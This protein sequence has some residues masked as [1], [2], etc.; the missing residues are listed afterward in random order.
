MIAA[1]S[2]YVGKYKVETEAETINVMKY[3]II[4]IREK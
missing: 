2:F 4:K 3:Q 1:R